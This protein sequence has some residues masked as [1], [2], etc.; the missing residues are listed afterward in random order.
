MQAFWD[1]LTPKVEEFAQATEKDPVSAMAILYIT[2]RFSLDVKPSA[3]TPLFQALV[4][5][6]IDYKEVISH[7]DEK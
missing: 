2:E 7:F 6:E 1:M 4:N 5:T 3:Y